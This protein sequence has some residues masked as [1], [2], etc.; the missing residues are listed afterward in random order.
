MAR[1]FLTAI[2]G[3]LFYT[4]QGFADFPKNN[5]HLQDSLDRKDANM[6]EE[7]FA[8]ITNRII[9]IYK[10][11]AEANGA[12]I[13]ANLKWKDETVNAFATQFSNRWYINMFGGLARRPE[14]TKDGYA[15]VVCHELGHH[16]GGFPLKTKWAANEGQSDY[17]AT[18]ACA[19]NIWENEIEENAKSRETVNSVAKSKCDTAFSDENRQNL[20]YRTAMAGLSLAKLLAAIRGEGANPNFG[21]QDSSVV[22]TTDMEHPRPQCRLDTYVAGALC[23]ITFDNNLIPG[24]ALQEDPREAEAEA[25]LYSCARKDGHT[26]STRP[27]CWYKPSI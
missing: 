14:I 18:H 10:P 8:A 7:E 24:K 15:M 17:F 6:T 26:Y 2:L 19:V 25:N 21:T 23:D 13:K 4:Q 20:C 22:S 11:F 9:E 16:F 12:T 27:R 5:L 3:C 1:I